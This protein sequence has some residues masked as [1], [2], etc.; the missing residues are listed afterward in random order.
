MQLNVILNI[1]YPKELLD[2]IL[3]FYQVDSKRKLLDL[4][5]G[6][7]QLAI[8]LHKYFKEVI[9]IDISQEMINEA[10]RISLDKNA[11]NI[12]FYNGIRK[13]R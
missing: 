3:K 12:S 10:R 13:N 1:E 2:I 7:G 9:A 5:C 8:P 4:G 6:T 11:Q